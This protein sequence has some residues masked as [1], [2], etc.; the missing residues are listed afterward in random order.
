MP[1]EETG[2]YSPFL[3]ERFRDAQLLGFNGEAN[4]HFLF[5]VILTRYTCLFAQ[6]IGTVLGSWKPR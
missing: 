4:F 2:L 6:T 3:L 5:W 1:V